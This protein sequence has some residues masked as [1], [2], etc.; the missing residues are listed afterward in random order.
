MSNTLEKIV[1]EKKED[2]NEYKNIFY[3]DDLKKK[4]ISY[5]N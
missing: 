1:S 4:I 5:K 2:I 3:I